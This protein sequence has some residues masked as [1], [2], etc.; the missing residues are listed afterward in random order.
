MRYQSLFLKRL[1]CIIH[2]YPDRIAA[3]D[4]ERQITYADLEKESAR[5][6][7]ALKSEGIGREDCILIVMKRGV[8][9]FPCILGIL[10]AGACFVALEEGYPP[11]RMERIRRDAGCV[12]VI[13]DGIYRQICAAASPLLGQEEPDPHDAA[14][15]V[16]TSGSTGDPKGVIQGQHQ[17]RIGRQRGSVPDLCLCMQWEKDCQNGS[18]K[19]SFHHCLH[20]FSSI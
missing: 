17:G 1:S 3:S 11:E 8:S 20:R 10:K 6:Y 16:Y 2:K 9:F 12:K 14:Y 13:D 5:V 7:H 15:Y 19:A 18:R 4:E